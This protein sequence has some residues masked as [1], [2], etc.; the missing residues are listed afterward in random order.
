MGFIAQLALSYS[1]FAVEWK[2]KTNCKQLKW[3]VWVCSSIGSNWN[4]QK[5]AQYD[6]SV[7]ND[8]TKCKALTIHEFIQRS[9]MFNQYLSRWIF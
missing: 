6:I 4:L 3:T 7:A 2:I 5:Y 8:V 9:A 1:L